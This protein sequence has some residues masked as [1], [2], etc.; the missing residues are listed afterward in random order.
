MYSQT[1][2]NL[3]GDVLRGF[4]VTVFAYGPTGTFFF[5]PVLIMK[6]SAG[7]RMMELRGSL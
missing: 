4:N 6:F 2:K 1:T 7:S 5:I 3:I